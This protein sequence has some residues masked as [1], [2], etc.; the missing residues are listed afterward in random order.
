[1][2]RNVHKITFGKFKGDTVEQHLNAE[3]KSYL[4]WADE[5]VSF[6]HLTDDEK[7]RLNRVVPKPKK[8][9]FTRPSNHLAKYH[10]LDMMEEKEAETA[11]MNGWLFDD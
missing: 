4:L 10:Q 6:F 9:A 8:A 2:A 1:M 11:S 5:N 7:K 3:D